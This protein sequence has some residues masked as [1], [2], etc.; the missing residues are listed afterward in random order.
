[1]SY[2]TDAFI[3]T[4]TTLIDERIAL[5]VSSITQDAEHTANGYLNTREAAEYIGSPRSRLYDLVALGDLIPH[6]DGTRLK[7][8][9][10]QLDTYMHGGN[11]DTG[12]RT[13]VTNT[14]RRKR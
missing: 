3:D 7:F 8:T 13:R 2:A 12:T 1:M 14:R 9:K 5:A 10:D 11:G 6:R 4:L